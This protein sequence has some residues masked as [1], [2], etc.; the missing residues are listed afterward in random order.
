MRLTLGQNSSYAI[1]QADAIAI[2]L[3]DDGQN[4]G[5]TNSW[6]S[7][8][9]DIFTRSKDGGRSYLGTINTVQGKPGVPALARII[10]HA[11]CPGAEGWEIEA[12]GPAS[13]LDSDGL[14]VAVAELLAQPVNLCGWAPT[15]GI[16]RVFGRF[17]INGNVATATGGDSTAPLANSRVDF[18]QPT[19]L[20]QAFGSN[21]S[22]SG[23]WIMFFDAQ[24]VPPNG[25]QPVHGLS[26][27][28][29]A[30]NTFNFVAPPNGIFLRNGLVWAL[31]TT[32]GALT[33]ALGSPGGRVTTVTLW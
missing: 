13:G 24:A 17:I 16:F 23:A 18:V 1:G 26:F 27:D 7:W 15:V 2:T 29:A 31:S 8:Q 3:S 28:L 11:V 9:L 10:A 14:T 4:F 19:V 32:S 12:T 30:G 20:A 33:L 5:S 21:E 25:T 22:G 6:P